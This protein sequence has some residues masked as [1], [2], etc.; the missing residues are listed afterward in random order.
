M[1]INFAGRRCPRKDTLHPSLLQLR[2][3][4]PWHKTLLWRGTGKTGGTGDTKDFS[5]PVSCRAAKQGRLSN[6]H[7]LQV[8]AVPNGEVRYEHAQKLFVQ[9]PFT[10]TIQ[11]QKCPRHFQCGLSHLGDT[12]TETSST[13]LCLPL[14]R[15]TRSL[16]VLLR[17]SSQACCSF[18]C[19]TFP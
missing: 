4:L 8:N 17:N 7:T 13:I 9:A 16:L 19:L 18:W 10:Q 14:E 5:R 1:A 12:G 2:I 6:L 15:N 11:P 3:P